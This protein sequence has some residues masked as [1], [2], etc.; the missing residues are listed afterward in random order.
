[1]EIFRYIMCNSEM[2]TWRRK[3]LIE[4]AN[5][6]NN[7][8]QGIFVSLIP[9][10]RFLFKF[11]FPWIWVIEAARE[12]WNYSRE[13]AVLKMFKSHCWRNYK[14]KEESYFLVKWGPAVFR[15]IRKLIP[16]CVHFIISLIK[17]RIR[18]Y[19]YEINRIYGCIYSCLFTNKSQG[20]INN[21]SRFIT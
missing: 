12:H 18:L 15:F 5:I 20:G 21:A 4:I 11:V 6:N 17:S 13:K 16:L 14:G 9:I 2:K 10:K 7:I 19:T 3:F 8:W 1:M